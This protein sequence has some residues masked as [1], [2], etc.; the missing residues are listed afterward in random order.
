MPLKKAPRFHSCLSDDGRYS[1]WSNN[2]PSFTQ[3]EKFRSW[4]WGLATPQWTHAWPLHRLTIPRPGKLRTSCSLHTL[5]LLSHQ[6]PTAS[7]ITYLHTLLP[8]LPRESLH[9][10]SFVFSVG[11]LPKPSCPLCW[12][13]ISNVQTELWTPS[14]KPSGFSITSKMKY[15]PLWWSH[16]DVRHHVI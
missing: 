15:K 11:D 3:R 14:E 12:W 7:A 6:V 9:F 10:S 2:V 8:H 16:G 13:D 1:E 5:H 4:L